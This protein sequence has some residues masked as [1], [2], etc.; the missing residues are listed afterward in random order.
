MIEYME[1]SIEVYH[2]QQDDFNIFHTSESTLM[3]SE[4]LKKE[5]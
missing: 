4:A 2:C 5:L 1:N 3:F